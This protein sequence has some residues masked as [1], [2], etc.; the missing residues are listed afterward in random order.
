MAEVLFEFDGSEPLV[1][2]IQE[3]SRTEQQPAG[4]G[5]LQIE[6][7]TPYST[8]DVREAL[9]RPGSLLGWAVFVGGLLGAG[10]AYFLQWYLVAYLYPLN[11]GGRPP[12]MP[13]AF[14]PITFE[15]GVL[16]ASFTA[17]FGTLMLGRLVRLWH[18]VF[19]ADGF[20]SV[21]VDK[22]WLSVKTR[23]LEWTPEQI[24]EQAAALGALR[25]LPL[26]AQ[27]KEERR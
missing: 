24:A 23:E 16:F 27:E 13:L 11:V 1:R 25:G 6:A 12:H 18:P 10:G 5:R 8:E 21:S 7:F 17:F 22:F 14:V 2:A 9:G 4:T 19:E 26:P 3:L 20:E 15:M